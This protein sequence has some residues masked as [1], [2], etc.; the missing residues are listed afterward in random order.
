MRDTNR[1]YAAAYG[2]IEALHQHGINDII[3]SPGSRNTP[4]AYAASDHPDINLHTVLDERAA[5][6]AAIGVS[7]ATY[8]RPVGLI[9][10]SGTAATE[11][12]PAA[13]EARLARVP[14]ILLTAD[15]PP[16]D[17][18]V[19]AP[20]TM[21]QTNLYGDHVKAS[22]SPGPPEASD[23][24]LQKLVSHTARLSSL[25][26]SDPMGPVHLNLAFR[27][28]LAPV[29]VEGDA[30]SFNHIPLGVSGVMV[31][32]PEMTEEAIGMLGERPL[33]IAGGGTP[34]MAWDY[35][36][37]LNIPIATD[38]LFGGSR[39]P[40]SVTK[41]GF[42]VSSGMLD[43]PL[44]PSGVIRFGAIATSKGLNT[45]L[46]EHPHIPQILVDPGGWRDPNASSMVVF[47]VDPRQLMLSLLDVAKPIEPGW[48][49]A[50]MS[51]EE[52]AELAIGSLPFPSE[53]AVANIVAQESR[54]RTINVGSGMPVR[55]LD[56]FAGRQEITV[57]SNRGANGI[58]GVISSAAGS[59][60]TRNEVLLLIGDLGFLHDASG[61]LTAQA[62]DVRMT[63]VLV[64]NGGGGI[65]HFLP[66][67]DLPGPFELLTAPHAVDLGKIAEGAGFR[68]ET[69]DT[70]EQ[71]R[72]ALGSHPEPLR[73]IEVRTQ[74][75]SNRTLHDQLGAAVKA[76]LGV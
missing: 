1:N 16:E 36:E 52:A 37:A 63:I 41:I 67:A 14:L 33:I 3:L 23:D 20:Q 26:I 2:V 7:K 72:R 68:H 25:A 30:P 58:D 38:V 34:L 21:S 51:A 28:P 39:K 66:Q 13:A 74:M 65:F 42:L 56:A 50:W 40:P 60:V 12:L 10:S 57:Y 53:P 44:Q 15:R 6:F 69:A 48:L 35:A 11:Y 49:E 8:L 71:L 27:E 24:W 9:C 43:G 73:V 70:P 62:L 75:E 4:L 18:D 64:N 55:D 45:W 5:A 54:G 76:A 46:A 32:G 31:P 17:H 29:H 59:A 61:L 47:D 22:F 19:G